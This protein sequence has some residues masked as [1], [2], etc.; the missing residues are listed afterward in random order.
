MAFGFSC[1]VYRFRPFANVYSVFFYVI[2]YVFCWCR[3]DSEEEEGPSMVEVLPPQP[4]PS[5]SGRTQ[6]VPRFV[7]VIP[8]NKD[9]PVCPLCP[10]KFIIT[11]PK[12]ICTT[13]KAQF[14]KR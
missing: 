8:Q 2:N 10:R 13:C 3:V 11:S 6:A 7:P 1:L 4:T 9:K 14:H 5:G 12:S